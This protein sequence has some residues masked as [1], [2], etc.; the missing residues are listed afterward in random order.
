MRVFNR[1]LGNVDDA[2]VQ[3]SMTRARDQAWMTAKTFSGVPEDEW[4]AAIRVHDDRVMGIAQFVSNPGLL[5]SAVT[6]IVRLGEVQD[7]ASVIDILK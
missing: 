2:L 4:P 1:L 3:F 6:H 5:L 7:P